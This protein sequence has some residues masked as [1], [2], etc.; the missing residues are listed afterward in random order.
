MLCPTPL[1]A[2]AWR[3]AAAL[4]IILLTGG[5][6]AAIAS[7][8]DDLVVPVIAYRTVGAGNS[9]TVRLAQ[10]PGGVPLSPQVVPIGIRPR[11]KQ[12]KA[13]GIFGTL[14]GGAIN[15]VSGSLDS[16]TAGL[17]RTAGSI[18]A[19]QA[20]LNALSTPI[21]ELSV[22][23]DQL[24]KPINDLST[25]ITDLAKP[26]DELKQPLKNLA[27]PIEGL[28]TP[29]ND[30][31]HSASG[32][33]K[34]LDGLSQRLVNLGKPLNGIEQPLN[35]MQAPLKAL[36][37]PITGLVD[38]LRSLQQPLTRL[39]KP[40]TDLA[41]PIQGLAVE[42]HELRMQVS[43][44]ENTTLEVGRDITLAIIFGSSVVAYAI[45]AHRKVPAATEPTVTIMERQEVHDEF[46]DHEETIIRTESAATARSHSGKP[47]EF[48]VHPVGVGNSMPPHTHSPSHLDNDNLPPPPAVQP[49]GE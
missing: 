18:R 20:P 4:T 14:F 47:G 36:P 6:R 21:H 9:E 5:S 34:P 8:G 49:P 48:S 45:W 29:V 46:G 7:D 1:C 22:P 38:P 33:N 3:L 25:P 37:G 13:S 30:L 16:T 15:P 32:L 10:I 23:I 12:H 35:G 27:T 31:S 42:M 11:F 39:Q 19:L 17:Y 41:S 2:L 28:Q 44:A 24:A 43:E 26:I 40:L